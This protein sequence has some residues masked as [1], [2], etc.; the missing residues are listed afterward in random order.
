MNRTTEDKHTPGPWVSYIAYNADDRPA[1]YVKEGVEATHTDMR[2]LSAA[3]DM[4]AELQ[5]CSF[6]LG[7]ML[8]NPD[9]AS[10]DMPRRWL[11]GVD[12]VIS[13]ATG[14]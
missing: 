5:R 6:E 12:Y 9:H 7:Q 4:L 14:A 11:R 13:Q 8:Q 3:P 10:P 2:L 1:L